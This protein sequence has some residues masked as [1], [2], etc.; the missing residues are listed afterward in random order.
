MVL[1]QSISL[2]RKERASQAAATEL[3]TVSNLISS[4]LA[5]QPEKVCL[6]A[7]DFITHSNKQKELSNGVMISVTHSL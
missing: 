1:G 6:F 5:F 4:S 2:H 3:K 7:G